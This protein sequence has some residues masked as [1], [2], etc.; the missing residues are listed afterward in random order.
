M[1]CTKN[2]FNIRMCT[3]WFSYPHDWGMLH[4]S[5]WA[6]RFVWDTFLL[7]FHPLPFDAC[8]CLHISPT[9]WI[10]SLVPRI[11]WRFSTLHSSEPFLLN[12]KEHVSPPAKASNLIPFRFGSRPLKVLDSNVMNRLKAKMAR[13]IGFYISRASSLHSSIPFTL[14]NVTIAL[15]PCQYLA[16]P[17]SSVSAILVGLCWY[18]ILVLRRHSQRCV[19]WPKE[20]SN[21][22]LQDM[23]RDYSIVDFQETGGHI[24]CELATC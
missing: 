9:C 23:L 14:T 13:L 8:A 4:R 5:S 6:V 15:C 18:F 16:L 20:K 3:S 12:L 1:L 21:P 24:F 17:F 10:L 19:P 7:D 22:S 2:A 11:P